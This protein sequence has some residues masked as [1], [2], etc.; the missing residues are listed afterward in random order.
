MVRI[1]VSFA[2]I[3]IFLIVTKVVEEMERG[4]PMST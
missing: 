4:N 2:L 1:G 3:A